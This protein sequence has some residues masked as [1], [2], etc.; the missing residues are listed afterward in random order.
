MAILGLGQWHSCDRTF[1]RHRYPNHPLYAQLLILSACLQTCK[2]QNGTTMLGQG[3]VYDGVPHT[4]IIGIVLGA[5][6]LATV[7]AIIAVKVRYKG[8]TIA[9]PSDSHPL[10]AQPRTHSPAASDHNPQSATFSERDE[11]NTTEDTLV[12]PFNG[13]M[14]REASGHLEV[15]NMEDPTTSRPITIA[16]KVV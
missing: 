15:M 6:A 8:R 7:L 14:E 3:D 4:T 10:A 1:R 9:R 2:A 13:S 5:I 11:L 16:T 12:L